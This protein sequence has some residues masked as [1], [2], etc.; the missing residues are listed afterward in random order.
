MNFL[1]LHNL[2]LLRLP[3]AARY[4][5]WL[6][7]DAKSVVKGSVIFSVSVLNTSAFSGLQT[8]GMRLASCMPTV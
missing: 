3:W 1:C 6:T 2:A 7:G 4:N 8:M 5:T